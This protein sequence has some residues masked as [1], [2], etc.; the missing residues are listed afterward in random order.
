MKNFIVLFSL[1]ILSISSFAQSE[2]TF[3]EFS[4]L[5]KSITIEKDYFSDI[6]SLVKEN[7]N[8]LPNSFDKNTSQ[9]FVVVDS[10]FKKQNLL[11][12][13]WDSTK[14]S[15]N[16][17]SSMTKISTGRTGSVHH[18]ITP[19]GWI[20]QIPENGTYRAEGTKNENGIRGYGIKG[21]R[22]WDFGWQKAYTGWLKNP[23]L[24][25]IRMQM[26]A[27]DPQYLEPRL[28]QPA[29]K[30]CVRVSAETNQFLDKFAI[31]DKNIE[32]SSQSWALKKDRTPVKEEG[33][34][35]LVINSDK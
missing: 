14:Q 12:G 21:M 23:E 34:F 10:S 8:Q 28:G 13:F 19:V 2:N 29:S 9:Y 22:V 16:L 7:F 26:H 18:Y 6:E 20:E 5:K 33:S 25:D 11:L 24:R 17:S 35:I 27:T 30:G 4:K 32:N 1:S 31:L 15:F 3:S